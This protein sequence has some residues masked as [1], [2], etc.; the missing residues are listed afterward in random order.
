MPSWNDLSLP[1]Q[2]VMVGAIEEVNLSDLLYDWNPKW[3]DGDF[4]ADIQV[5]GDAVVALNGRRLIEISFSSRL[6]A[7]TDDEVRDVVANLGAWVP[8][9]DDALQVVGWLSTTDAGDRVVETAERA[10]M[11]A[12]R[13]RPGRNP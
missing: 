13:G 8:G 9:E 12:Y 7:L 11:Y 3:A 4:L 10:T 6:P 2:C 5:L 1:Q